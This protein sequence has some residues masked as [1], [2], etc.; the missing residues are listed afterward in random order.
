MILRVKN[1]KI[2]GYGFY[3]NTNIY[4][5]FK[6]CISVPLNHIMNI[7][8]WCS[9]LL[10]HKVAPF[11]FPVFSWQFCIVCAIFMSKGFGV[12]GESLSDFSSNTK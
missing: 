11:N 7:F 5:D 4:G 8:L 3:M 2:L 6:I 12:V 9:M 1:S 10:W